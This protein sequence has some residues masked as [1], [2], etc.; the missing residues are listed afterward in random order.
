MKSSLQAD[1]D[2]SRFA[3]LVIIHSS[4]AL[5]SPIL[6]SGSLSAS[7]DH[8]VPRLGTRSEYAQIK[9]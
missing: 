7:L 9:G 2:K 6:Q 1:I 3:D 5:W 8:L 4:S